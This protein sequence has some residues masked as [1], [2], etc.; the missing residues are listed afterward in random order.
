MQPLIGLEKYIELVDAE[1]VKLYGVT[2]KDLGVGDVS[3]PWFGNWI[4][5]AC[6]KQVPPREFANEYG[7]KYDLILFDDIPHNYN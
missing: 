1:M 6:E 5:D 4:K 3:D 2:F 7:D